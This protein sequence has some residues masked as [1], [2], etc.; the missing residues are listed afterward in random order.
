[1]SERTGGEILI[2]DA[3]IAGLMTALAFGRQRRRL[4][5]F[6]QRRSAALPDQEE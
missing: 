3:G 1:M 6:E 4:R 5:L 2:V